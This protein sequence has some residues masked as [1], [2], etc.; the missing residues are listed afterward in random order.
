MQ[1]SKQLLQAGVTTVYY[2]DDFVPADPG[3]REA[4]YRLQQ[5]FSGGVHQ[6]RPENSERAA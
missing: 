2:E 3:E 5:G 4:Y 6:L 1:C